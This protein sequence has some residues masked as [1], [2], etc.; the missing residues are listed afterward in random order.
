M[1]I[2][3]ISVK[4]SPL[5]P[6][7]WHMALECGHDQWVTSSN[8]PSRKKQYCATCFQLQEETVLLYKA[9]GRYVAAHGGSVIVAGGIQIQQWPGENKFAFSVAVKCTGRKPDFANRPIDRR[10]TA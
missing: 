2:K 10:N 4:R 5:N 7:Q 8:K 9:V 1:N 3:V 6:R